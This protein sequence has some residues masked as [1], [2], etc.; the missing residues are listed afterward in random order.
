VLVAEVVGEPGEPVH[1][2]E[3]VTD[4]LRQQARGHREVLVGGLGD[5]VGGGGYGRN[6]TRRLVRL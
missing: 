3:V 4:R 1:G 2:E 5:E 6:G